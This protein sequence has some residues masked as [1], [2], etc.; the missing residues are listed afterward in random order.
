MY[1]LSLGAEE[2]SFA[3]REWPGGLPE[4]ATRALV[5]SQL[6]TGAEI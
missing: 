3:R 2:D 4:P 6:L 5:G 1:E